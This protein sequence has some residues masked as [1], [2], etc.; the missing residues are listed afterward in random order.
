LKV[1]GKCRDRAKQCQI[2]G[3][4]NQCFAFLFEPFKELESPLD[5]RNRPLA[6]NLKIGVFLKAEPEGLTTTERRGR[7]EVE[8]PKVG[9]K[10]EGAGATESK[11]TEGEWIISMRAG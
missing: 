9:P 7:R 5:P 6:G 10:G 1:R 3:I 8:Q 11:N 4:E 2:G